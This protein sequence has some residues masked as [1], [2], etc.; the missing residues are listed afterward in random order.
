MTASSIATLNQLPE[1]QKLAVYARFI[2]RELLG[3][4]NLS[5]D[6]RDGQ[7]NNLLTL[8]SQP[9][10]T[11]VVLDLRHAVGA[12]DPLLYAH[13]TD[14]MNGQIH[15]LLYIVNDPGSPRYDVDKM[16]DG[17]ST[18]FG[19]FHRNLAAEA[20]ALEAGLAPGQLRSGLGML[21]Q[22][23]AAFENFIDYLGHD[24]YF[25]DPLAYHNAIVFERYGFHYQQGRRRMERINRGFLPDGEY[26]SLLDDSSPFRKSIF[27]GSIRGRSWAIHDGILGEPYTAIVMY[28]TLGVHAGVDTFPNAAW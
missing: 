1:D 24:V 11:D 22:S 6:F 25:I 18:E 28:K 19:H 26:A 2:P 5:E 21:S 27:A 16:P 20:A 3:R 12:E 4:F 17:T 13:L 15:V 7:G 14:T 8:R 10:S 23:V 9:G